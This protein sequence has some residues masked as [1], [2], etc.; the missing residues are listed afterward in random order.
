MAKT[1]VILGELGEVVACVVC[2][3]PAGDCEYSSYTSYDALLQYDILVCK[4]RGKL[5]YSKANLKRAQWC[6][7]HANVFDAERRE[8]LLDEEYEE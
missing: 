5:S 4:R 7:R 6:M 3:L 1:G 2:D 8:F